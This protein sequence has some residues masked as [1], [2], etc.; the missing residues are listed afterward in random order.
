MSEIPSREAQLESALQAALEVIQDYL[1]YEHSG[2]P[3]E[4][5]ART[6]GEMDINDYATDG[7]M[8]YALNLLG[9]KS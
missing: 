6:M 8:E 7:R 2:D 1:T 3:W 9:I 4:E 5:D